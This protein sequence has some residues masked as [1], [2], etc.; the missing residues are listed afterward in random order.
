MAINS[1]DDFLKVY[2][3]P[4]LDGVIVGFSGIDPQKKSTGSASESGYDPKALTPEQQDIVSNIVNNYIKN[5]NEELT[6]AQIDIIATLIREQIENFEVPTPEDNEVV[7]NTAIA[8]YMSKLTIRVDSGN[9]DPDAPDYVEPTIPLSPSDVD[10][11]DL[12]GLLGGNIGGHYHLTTNERKKLGILI[13]ELFPNGDD[14][15][16]IPSSGGGGGNDTPTPPGSGGNDNP[17]GDDDPLGGLPAG[18][19]PA[20][21]MHTLPTGYSFVESKVYY[22]TNAL[23]M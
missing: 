16:I 6:E 12:G 13:N 21:K 4:S 1:Y 5:S 2:E 11:E 18:T 20:W 10:H 17:I 23:T 15:F 3:K 7:I 9:V 19:P 14:E 8:K 22:G